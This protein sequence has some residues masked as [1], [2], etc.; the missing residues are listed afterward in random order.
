MQ[1]QNGLD[2]YLDQEIWLVTDFVILVALNVFEPCIN[3]CI[4]FNF[5]TG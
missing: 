4:H 5:C 3:V 2:Y 1:F